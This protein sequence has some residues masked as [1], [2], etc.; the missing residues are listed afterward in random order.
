MIEDYQGKNYLMVHDY[1]RDKVLERIKE[2]IGIETF[3]D[4]KLLIDTYDKYPDDVAFK[5]NLILVRAL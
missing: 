3:D 1:I 2:I 4:T 5:Y